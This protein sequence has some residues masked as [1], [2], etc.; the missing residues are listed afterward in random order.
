MLFYF[1]NMEY[2]TCFK[3][4]LE[5]PIH[6]FYV[7]PR[8]KDGHLNKC[9]ECAKKDVHDS[10]KLKSSD[11][12]FLEKERERCR[13]KYARLNYK[14]KY[15]RC[16]FD[17]VS[18]LK[19]ISKRLKVRGLYERGKEAHH[20]N[21]NIPYSLILLGRKEHACIHQHLTVDSNDLFCYTDKGEKLTTEDQT[22]AYHQMILRENG[23]KD[24]ISIINIK[25]RDNVN[26]P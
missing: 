7:H 4:G 1:K 23:F 12:K 22:L 26:Y 6:E 16:L 21:Y 17:R 15:K 24:D 20:W 11:E 13:I 9:K 2:K 19:C 14:D 25:I 10:Y 3:C 18:K 5:K 8:M